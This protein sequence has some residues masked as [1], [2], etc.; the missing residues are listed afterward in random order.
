MQGIFLTR[1]YER[2]GEGARGWER[3]QE[4]GIERLGLRICRAYSLQE[5]MR[6]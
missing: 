1:D 4:A 6:G 5:I 2:L 3:A